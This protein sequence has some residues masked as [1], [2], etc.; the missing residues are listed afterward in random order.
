MFDENKEE[1]YVAIQEYHLAHQK[2]VIN[3][4]F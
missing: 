1:T 3:T 2:K 4:L